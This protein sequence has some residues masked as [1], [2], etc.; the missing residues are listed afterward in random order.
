MKR[1]RTDIGVRFCDTDMIGH[2]NNT[3]IAQYAE[4]GRV[5]F[6]RTLELPASTLILVNISIDFT[7]QIHVEDDVWIETWASKIGR[8]SLTLKQEL[9]ANGRVAARTTSVAVTFD[10]DANQPVPVPDALRAL[11]VDYLEEP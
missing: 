7:A 6:F 11:L 5:G 3:A 4:S 2:I 9:F 10:Y 8:T 1:V